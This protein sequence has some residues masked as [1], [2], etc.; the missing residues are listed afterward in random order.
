MVGG[1]DIRFS[2]KNGR[3]SV[4]G[5]DVTDRTREF[6]K[7]EWAK[8][9]KSFRTVLNRMP[10]RREHNKRLKNQR[11]TSSVN[12]DG[13]SDGI[14]ISEAVQGQIVSG[15]ARAVLGVNASR[16][17]PPPGVVNVQ[18][19]RMGSGG[20]ASRTNGRQAAA[21]QARAGNDNSS[22][23]SDISTLRWDMNGNL[24]NQ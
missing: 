3:D 2:S 21:T 19:P 10:E 7:D 16:D 14:T 9:P 15:V 4:N 18:Q 5:V 20:A 22:V 11:N 1:K 13:T 24:I 17:T 6:T 8:L 23:V 12:T